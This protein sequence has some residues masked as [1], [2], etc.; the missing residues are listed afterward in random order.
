MNILATQIADYTLTF[1]CALCLCVGGRVGGSC[2]LLVC[3]KV[4][5]VF[6]F[7]KGRGRWLLYN[8]M[9]ILYVCLGSSA[10]LASRL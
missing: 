4:R 7:R 8:I 1:C 2:L 3:N 9:S 6:D 5:C 10:V